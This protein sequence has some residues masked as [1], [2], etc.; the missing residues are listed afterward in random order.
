MNNCWSQKGKGILG[1]SADNGVDRA[2]DPAKVTTEWGSGGSKFWRGGRLGWHTFMPFPV[3]LRRPPSEGLASWELS[4]CW[5]WNVQ[6]LAS[7]PVRQDC[8]VIGQL[9]VRHQPHASHCSK[10]WGRQQWIRQT[11]VWALMKLTT[12]GRRDKRD[13][14]YPCQK[15]S[16]FWESFNV[17]N[18][19]F[20]ARVI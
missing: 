9:L 7:L 5:C 19:Y 16:L 3:V 8:S 17:I 10:C 6:A 4:R 18:C 2:V 14:N 20:Q 15:R 1:E 13:K 11:N 12:H